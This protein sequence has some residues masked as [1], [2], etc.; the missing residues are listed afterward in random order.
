MQ[1]L[2]ILLYLVIK[3]AYLR[4]KRLWYCKLYF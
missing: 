2:N 4:R 1:H 3:L